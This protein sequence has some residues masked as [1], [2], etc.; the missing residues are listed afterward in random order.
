EARRTRRPRRSA[1]CWKG[2]PPPD[3]DSRTFVE[4]VPVVQGRTQ[5]TAG[6]RRVQSGAARWK[7]PDTGPTVRK[8]CGGGASAPHH[9]WVPVDPGRARI[10]DRRPGCRRF[11]FLIGDFQT[12]SG[13]LTRPRLLVAGARRSIPDPR[14]RLDVAG[15]FV[16]V[17]VVV[18]AVVARR[19]TRLGV[20]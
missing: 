17:A 8:A 20:V 19:L 18:R 7:I 3:R 15:R 13:G 6:V 1:A 14:V 2:A 10:E 9:G 5:P 11:Y 16:G 4:I 12:P